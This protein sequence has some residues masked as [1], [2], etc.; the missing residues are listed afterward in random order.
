ME[1]YYLPEGNLLSSPQNRE[2]ISSLDGLERAMACGA[3]IEG[4]AK[5]CDSSFDLHVDFPAMPSV[6]GII[7]R[8]ECAYVKNGEEIKDIA[9][10]TRVGKAVCFKVIGIERRPDGIVAHLSRRLAQMECYERYLS[11][12]C[13]G[14]IIN[15]R[16]THLEPFGAFVDIGCGMVSLLSVDAISVSRIS[17][18][19]DRLYCGQAIWAVVR[20]IDRSNDRIFVSMRELLGTWEENAANF[21]SGQT[22]AG[23]I[24]SVEDYG[25]FVELSPNLAGLAEVREED[26]EIYRSMIGRGCAVFIKSIIPERMKIK[27]VLLDSYRSEPTFPTPL[28]YYIHGDKAEHIDSWVYSPVGARK[29]VETVFE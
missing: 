29:R 7:P 19:R 26:R 21:E 27:L 28:T 6:R 15:A 20:S 25:V 22:V 1:K 12:L 23:I 17:H 2:F 14:D 18:P 3:I 16:V 9:V 11:A 10:L 5:L 24:R 4:I 13:P 8:A